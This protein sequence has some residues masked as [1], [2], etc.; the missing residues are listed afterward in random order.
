MAP[1]PLP[2]LKPNCFPDVHKYFPHLSNK[3]NSNTLDKE[4]DINSYRIL[5][6]L[7]LSESDQPAPV[8]L[9]QLSGLHETCI[10]YDKTVYFE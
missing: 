9:V 2:T 5:F 10:D 7:N 6:G 4:F 8:L 1:V 3:I